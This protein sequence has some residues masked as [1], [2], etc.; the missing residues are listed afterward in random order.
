MSS[1]SEDLQLP[2]NSLE[3][4]RDITTRVLNYIPDVLDE[5][6][7]YNDYTI[8]S[9]NI[10]GTRKS[11]RPFRNELFISNQ[12]TF[13]DRYRKFE[14]L[15]GRLKNEERDYNISDHKMLDS[16]VYTMQ[17]SVGIGL[18]LM[19]Q[20]NSARKHVGNRFEELIRILFSSL[21]ISMKKIVLSI[22]YETED[23]N[24]F[25][26]CETDVVISPY[27]NVHS[28]S[29]TIHPNEIVI[30]V[31][32]TTKDRMP[33]IFID[34][35]LMERFVGHPVKVVGIS[36]NDIQRKENKNQTR[37]NYTFVSNLF[38]VYTQFL[39]KLEGYYYLDL[40]AR[41]MEKPFTEHIFPFSKFILSDIWILLR[42]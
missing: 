1:L 13:N 24:K 28:N 5:Q 22:P 7:Q 17:Q 34:K 42:S 37:I 15:L 32:T 30:S 27:Q 39:A 36:Q 16:V 21:D 3:E 20:A 8:C 14:K 18:D 26:R 6:V 9:S 12:N 35:V 40:P 23:G 25:Y 2:K 38:M 41:A 33:K 19:V 29:N 31:K 10:A 11:I 4:F